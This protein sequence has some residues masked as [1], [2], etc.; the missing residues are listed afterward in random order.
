[1]LGRMVA[2]LGLAGVPPRALQHPDA[3]AALR[4]VLRW[5]A[6]SS[7]KRPF[8]VAKLLV[9]TRPFLMGQCVEGW[10]LAALVNASCW[11]VVAG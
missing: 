10:N 7:I 1:V 11:W 5:V 9:S 8:C 2:G 4:A 6:M 3:R